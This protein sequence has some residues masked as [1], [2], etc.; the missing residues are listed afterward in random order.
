MNRLIKMICLA[1]GADIEILRRCP[2]ER[3]GFAAAGAGVI[4]VTLVSVISMTLTMYDVLGDGSGFPALSIALF[5]GFVIFT[6]YWGALSVIRRTAGYTA[7]IKISGA[8]FI[9]LTSLVSANAVI[10]YILGNNGFPESFREYSGAAAV[11]LLTAAVYAIPLVIRLLMNSS[12]YEEERARIWRNFLTQK[13]A[14][15]AA[16]GEKYKDYAREFSDAGIRMDM[17]R[18]LSEIS[19]EYHNIIEK[20]RRETFGFLDRLAKSGGGRETLADECRNKVEEGLKMTLDR[21]SETF[22]A[23]SGA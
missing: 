13:E 14:D 12:G 19:E 23:A 20:T 7:L 17:I 3:N 5:Y 2:S 9:G 18:Q 16:Y 8:V 4:N 15:I 6:G 11:I 22:S 10:R 1:G 21:M